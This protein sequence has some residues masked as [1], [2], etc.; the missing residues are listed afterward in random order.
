MVSA[1]QTNLLLENA[2]Q[3][4]AKVYLHQ[5]ISQCLSSYG[6][7]ITIVSIYL[8]IYLYIYI[9]V[10]ALYIYAPVVVSLHKLSLLPMHPADSPPVVSPLGH[11]D[12][13]LV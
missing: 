5:C 3:N 6:C 8:S 13:F 2:S 10:L 12:V 1:Q 11:N 9:Y 4:D 7:A